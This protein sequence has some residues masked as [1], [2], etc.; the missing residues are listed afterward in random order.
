MRISWLA[1]DEQGVLLYASSRHEGVIY[2]ISPGGNM[3]VYVEGITIL[4]GIVF[5]PEGNLYVGDRSGTI[6][7]ISRQRQS[8][9]VYATMEQPSIAAY[10]LAFGPD[11]YLYVTGP[12]GCVQLRFRSSH[13]FRGRGSKCSIEDSGARKAWRSTPKAI[14]TYPDRWADGAAWCA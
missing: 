9:R 13:F 14:C 7:K 6:F 2:Q 8:L 12:T 5:D 3:A 4:T 11:G 10:H 1:L